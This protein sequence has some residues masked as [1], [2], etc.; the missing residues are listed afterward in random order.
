MSTVFVTEPFVKTNKAGAYD[1]NNAADF[2]ILPDDKYVQPQTTVEA[3]NQYVAPDTVSN[4]L[5]LRIKHNLALSTA[6]SG[7]KTFAP[8]LGCFNL[9]I[10]KALWHSPAATII[11]VRDSHLILLSPGVLLVNWNN[12]AIISHSKK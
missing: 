6:S 12:S 11:D 2:L 5:E 7:I 9:G 10:S 8:R 4:P 1:S 3:F